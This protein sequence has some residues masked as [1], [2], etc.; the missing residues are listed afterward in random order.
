MIVASVAHVTAQLNGGCTMIQIMLTA[1][2]DFSESVKLQ[3]R[4]LAFFRCCYCLD[5][6]GD[7]VHHLVPK[8][9]GGSNTIDNA[10]L[11]CAQCHTTYGHTRDKR[12]QLQQAR[13]HWYE[14]A[15]KKYG[16]PADQQ[17]VSLQRS[18]GDVTTIGSLAPGPVN[19]DWYQLEERFD[20]IR[21]E[22]WAI[23]QRND[24]TG[25]VTWSVYPRDY[26]DSRIVARFLIEARI[27]GQLGREL[28]KMPVKFDDQSWDDSADTWLNVVAGLVPCDRFTGS[29]RD[30]ETTYT[31][32][33]LED[34]VDASRLA[35]GR[36]A[37]EF[38]TV[39]PMMSR[40]ERLALLQQFRDMVRTI[41]KQTRMAKN[42]TR[43]VTSLLE[44]NGD[45][46][47]F[48]PYMSER[49]RAGVYGRT[50]IVPPDQSEMS[51]VLHSILD[52]IAAIERRWG[53]E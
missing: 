36:I 11:L 9:E 2:A 17:S 35:C 18:G 30:G 5:R 19:P 27:A 22:V 1:G 45:F 8:E 20:R 39:Q 40:A 51:G 15:A 43:S 7:E 47:R 49:T 50:V 14:V 52:D 32:G 16:P 29:G 4:H 12:K 23:W 24:Q 31:S 33:S 42:A 26:E 28:L 34:V 48:A 21:G 37:T 44:M 13:D 46:L 38:V 10:I 25:K 53:L 6:P 41:H 3:A